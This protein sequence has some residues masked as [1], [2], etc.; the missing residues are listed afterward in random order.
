MRLLLLTQPK[1]TTHGMPPL[2]FRVY[3]FVSMV[4]LNP[5]GLAIK[6]NYHTHPL[7]F[8]LGPGSS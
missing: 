5:I 7:P 3:L 2:T 1:I 6:I 8:Y 4:I